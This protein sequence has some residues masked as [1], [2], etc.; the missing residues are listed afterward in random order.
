[1]DASVNQCK[2]CGIIFDDVDHEIDKCTKKRLYCELCLAQKNPRSETEQKIKKKYILITAISAFIILTILIV[3]NLEKNKNDNF[4]EYLVGFGFGYLIIW[5]FTS[6][7]L[8]PVLMLMKK[9]HKVQIKQ[10]KEKYIEEIEV[11]KESR[12]TQQEQRE[13]AKIEEAEG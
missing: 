13:R 10:E 4:F 12:K 1:M 7:F 11:K 5:G 8:F 3:I 6:I 9:P 2:S